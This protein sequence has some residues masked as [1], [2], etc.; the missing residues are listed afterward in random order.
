MLI[1]LDLQPT[2]W[3][4]ALSVDADLDNKWC[5]MTSKWGNFAVKCGVT[6]ESSSCKKTFPFP[7]LSYD[8]DPIQLGMREYNFFQRAI[9]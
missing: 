8:K 5:K 2:N 9:I 3:C 1:F 6:L 4:L 7:E